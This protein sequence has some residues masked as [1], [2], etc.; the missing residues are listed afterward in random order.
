MNRFA[1]ALLLAALT[2]NSA[3][4]FSP[5]TPATRKAP[6]FVTVTQEPQSEVETTVAVVEPVEKKAPAPI[7]KTPKAKGGHGKDGIF[8]PA[9]G[10]AKNVLGEEKLNQVRGKAISMHSKVIGDFVETAKSE[11]G[12]RVL[13]SLFELADMD[14]NGTIDEEELARALRSLGFDL[15]DKQVQGIF[16]RADKDGNGA[17]DLDEWRAAAPAT[18]RINLIKLAK[19][20]GGELG[21]LS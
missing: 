17:I 9:V 16:A 11:S 14:K 15:S 8:A 7:K 5:N 6:F 12:D 20:N 19:K 1:Y 4:A 13:Q 3:D 18:L 21:F 10:V 2:A